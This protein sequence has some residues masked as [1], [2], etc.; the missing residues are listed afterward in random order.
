MSDCEYN[1]II[2]YLYNFYS[3]AAINN[4]KKSNKNNLITEQ[5]SNRPYLYCL[6]DI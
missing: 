5:G 1:K 6:R 4:A 2:H 3:S